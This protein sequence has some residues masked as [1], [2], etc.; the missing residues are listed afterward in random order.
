MSETGRPACSAGGLL[1]GRLRYLQPARGNRTGLEPVLL[2]ASVPARPGQRV[3][4]AGTGAGAALLCLMAR[5]TGVQAVGVERDPAM[6]EVSRRNLAI[7]GFT[8]A[9][10][11]TACIHAVDAQELGGLMDHCFANPPWHDAR[12][13]PSP[14][15]G[16]E[17]ARRASDG[18]LQAWADSLSGLLRR[19]GTLSLALPA[20]QVDAGLLALRQ[21]ECGTLSVFPLWPRSGQPARLVLLRGVKGGR[22]TTSL[23]AGLVLHHQSKF[24]AAADVVLREGAALDW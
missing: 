9:R 13:T 1:G 11:L 15:P 4:E 6:A 17:A 24:T 18:L 5:V 16:R 23:H 2:A 7:N 12:G 3:L 22:G 19:G 20:G 21:S 8:S 10:V 14:M